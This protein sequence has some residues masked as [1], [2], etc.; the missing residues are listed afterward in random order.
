M[1]RTSQENGDEFMDKKSCRDP[2]PVCSFAFAPPQTGIHS[3]LLANAIDGLI[4]S[5][6]QLVVR[7]GH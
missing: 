1:L 5:H 7:H 2:D 3:M 6:D 4:G